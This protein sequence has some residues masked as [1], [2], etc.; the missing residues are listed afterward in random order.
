MC[1]MECRFGISKIQLD[2]NDHV[3][4][5]DYNQFQSEVTFYDILTG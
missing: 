3:S 4:M 1:S 5:H 2:V